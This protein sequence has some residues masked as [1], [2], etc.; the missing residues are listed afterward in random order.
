MML[1]GALIKIIS[2]LMLVENISLLH[3]KAHLQ[4]CL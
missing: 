2:S 3:L 1:Q 4:V